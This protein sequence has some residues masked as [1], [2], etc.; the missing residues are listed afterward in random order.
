MCIKLNKFIHSS[1]EAQKQ[2]NKN[3]PH[4]VGKNSTLLKMMIY[5]VKKIENTFQAELAENV[6]KLM[7]DGILGA[8]GQVSGYAR[9]VTD[10]LS[11]AN[12]NVSS[13]YNTI[14]LALSAL[15]VLCGSQLKVMNRIQQDMLIDPL[16]LERVSSTLAKGLNRNSHIPLRGDISKII[17]QIKSLKGV[18]KRFSGR[19]KKLLDSDYVPPESATRGT[20][21]TKEA[22][23]KFERFVSKIDRTAAN[24][25]VNGK[26]PTTEEGHYITNRIYDSLISGGSGLKLKTFNPWRIFPLD[27]NS[28]TSFV[29]S[30]YSV[31]IPESFKNEMTQK[32][33]TADKALQVV[34]NRYV[35]EH[36]K[37]VLK[38]IKELKKIS[39]SSFLLV[40]SKMRKESV[41]QSQIQL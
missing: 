1:F 30:K 15:G 40:T 23:L 37:R 24:S 13:K 17:E 9:E 27:N 7:P 32:G 21:L 35:L 11:M 20:A 28:P 8:K 29:K 34:W 39:G 26:I 14:R 4:F 18:L 5:D 3:Q 22:F 25:V 41:P 16:H 10:G 38:K 2:K 33:L 31:P 36:P 6:M 12:V 19:F